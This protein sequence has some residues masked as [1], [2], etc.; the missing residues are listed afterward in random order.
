[1]S[2]TGDKGGRVKSWFGGPLSCSLRTHL[3]PLLC[4]PMPCRVRIPGET[5][6]KD[7]RDEG[8]LGSQS[9]PA[10]L[11]GSPLCLW[12]GELCSWRSPPDAVTKLSPQQHL[13]Y[14]KAAALGPPTAALWAAVQHSGVAEP[15]GVLRA[16]APHQGITVTI[17][18]V[19]CKM[20]YCSVVFRDLWH[21][22]DRDITNSEP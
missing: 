14:R 15:W 20:F 1:M 22:T 17:C 19:P 18:S 7:G 3:V 5:K 12:A 11:T 2:R 8:S 6:L 16:A 13:H 21:S 10:S 4:S 9:H